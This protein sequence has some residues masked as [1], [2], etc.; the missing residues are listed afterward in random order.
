[1][2]SCPR[3][4]FVWVQGWHR[5]MRDRLVVACGRGGAPQPAVD[6]L[7]DALENG[8]M[9]TSCVCAFAASLNWVSLRTR[10]GSRTFSDWN[11]Q[12]Q[13][14]AQHSFG[15]PGEEVE[16]LQLQEDY[17]ERRALHTYEVRCCVL[18]PCCV[19]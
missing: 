14:L 2:L 13:R 4:S 11:L 1:M 6:E 8:V 5:G 7:V 10:L 12:L 15:R 17:L 3:E 19:S 16:A 18:L 9:T